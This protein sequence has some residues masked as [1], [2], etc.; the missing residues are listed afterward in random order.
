M[1]PF[2]RKTAA[3]SEVSGKESGS[4]SGFENF[5]RKGFMLETGKRQKYADSCVF[6]SVS[7]IIGLFA[8]DSGVIRNPKKV[9]NLYNHEIIKKMEILYPA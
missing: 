5:I 3:S 4:R 1:Y 7:G 9:T 6:W 2:Q 8:R